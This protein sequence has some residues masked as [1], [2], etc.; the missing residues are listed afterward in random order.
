MCLWSKVAAVQA[1]RLAEKVGL[2]LHYLDKT[3]S[4]EHAHLLFASFYPWEIMGYPHIDSEEG[5]TA[6][7]KG[8]TV[9]KRR[10]K[11]ARKI[12]VLVAALIRSNRLE[13]AL[14][15]C[16]ALK[17][18]MGTEDGAEPAAAKPERATGTSIKKTADVKQLQ[19]QF[20]HLQILFLESGA[21]TLDKLQ[22]YIS[23]LP[24]FTTKKPQALL[25][26]SSKELFIQNFK[27]YCCALEPDMLVELIA[28]F[29]NAETKSMMDE[30]ISDLDDFQDK[31]KLKDFVGQDVFS[32]PTPPE[33]KEV[34]L[35][36]GDDWKEETLADLSNLIF[37]ISQQPWL[38]KMLSVGSRS[39]N[40]TFMIPQNYD[41]EFGINIRCYLQSQY[42]L[43]ILVEGVYI[44]NCEGMIHE[45]L[46]D[47][48]H[49]YLIKV[50]H[51]L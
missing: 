34:Q 30:Y 15:F 45:L 51:F 37:N 31:T 3:F 43:Q 47:C 1:V 9:S 28:E 6:A 8:S 25:E 12:R 41:L 40:A 4:V 26:A 36:L 18:L 17:Q 39:I 16:Q 33:Y 10:K 22:R 13:K 5:Y 23:A 7:V 42:V 32:G 38:L 27:E 21:V 24:S 50:T 14:R 46:C 44:F 2:P 29:G 19:D 49:F 20:M 48:T 35:K 11:R